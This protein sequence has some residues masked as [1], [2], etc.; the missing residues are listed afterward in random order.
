VN[1][2]QANK[3]LVRLLELDYERTASFISG[4]VGTSASLRGWAV[5]I[6]LAVIGLAIDRGEA[7]VAGLA[8]LV[9]V[10]FFVVDGYHA[11]VYGQA[12]VHASELEQ[13]SALHYDALGRGLEDEDAQLDL[14]V[15]LE[16]HRFGMYRNFRRFTVSDLLYVRPHVIFRVFYPLL[17]LAALVSAAGLYIGDADRQSTCLIVRESVTEKVSCDQRLIVDLRPTALPTSSAPSQSVSPSQ[18]ASSA[19]TTKPPA[20]NAATAT[21]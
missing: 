2:E 7:A 18:S 21:P 12:V 3:E 11:W 10:A 1:R 8:A 13:I 15:G 4:V 14:Q 9:A 17:A 6:W 20:S 16:S 19:P 5:T